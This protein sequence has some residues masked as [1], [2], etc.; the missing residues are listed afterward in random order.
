MKK[1]I[2][3][4]EDIV[5]EAEISVREAY[6][7]GWNDGYSE[8]GVVQDKL[9]DPRIILKDFIVFMKGFKLVVYDNEKFFS[10]GEHAVTDDSIISN[11]LLR[12]DY[13]DEE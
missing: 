2:D 5:S 13:Y 6:Q 4:V 7:R 12:F 11:F 1:I 8:S 3:P 10:N 9:S